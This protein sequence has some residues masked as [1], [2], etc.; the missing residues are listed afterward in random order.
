MPTEIKVLALQSPQIII[1]ELAA[2]F[3]RR[4]GYRITQLLHHSDMP[5]QAKQ[6]TDAWSCSMLP[7]FCL[8]LFLSRSWQK[9]ARSL[10]TPAPAFY[11]CPS[12]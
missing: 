1:N 3:E 7:S 10:T 9:R 2:D 11:A 12:A 4:T 5:I 6:K 8:H